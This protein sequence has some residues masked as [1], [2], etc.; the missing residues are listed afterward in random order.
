M[1]RKKTLACSLVTNEKFKSNSSIEK[2]EGGTLEKKIAHYG[3]G[4]YLAVF[5][6][7]SKL[8]QLS[9]CRWC[10]IHYAHLT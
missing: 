1:Y 8:F 10:R 4:K 5:K 6:I 3:K 7:S 2:T 9:K